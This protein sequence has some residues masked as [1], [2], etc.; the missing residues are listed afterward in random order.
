MD[1]VL[2]EAGCDLVLTSRSL[3][4]AQQTAEKFRAKYKRDVLPL[5]LDVTRQPQIVEVARQ[6]AGWKGHIDILINNAGAPPGDGKAHL[7]ER[8]PEDAAMLIATGLNWSIGSHWMLDVFLRL[9]GLRVR[10]Q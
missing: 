7:F 10:P 3:D 4:S 2:A 1:D 5:A 6:A 8:A 9:K